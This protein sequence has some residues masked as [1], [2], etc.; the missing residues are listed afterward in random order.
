MQGVNM[1]AERVMIIIKCKGCDTSFEHFTR[2]PSLNKKEYCERCISRRKREGKHLRSKL[3][4][5]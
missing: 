2:K 4:T 1:K 3:Q 5:G